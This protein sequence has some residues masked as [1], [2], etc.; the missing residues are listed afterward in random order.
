MPALPARVVPRLTALGALAVVCF[1]SACDD[2]NSPERSPL[3]GLTYVISTD[4][5][6]SFMPAAPL[7]LVPGYFVGTVLG[8]KLP[9]SGNDSL[10]TMPRIAGAVVTAYPVLA[11]AGAFATVGDAEATAVTDA[12]GKFTLPEVPG[13]PYMLAV[14]PPEGSAFVGQYISAH[15]YSESH[16]FA[17]WL[18]LDRK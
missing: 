13:G 16:L 15:A 8:A 11:G 4:S 2:L 18:I 3:E 7:E 1:A 12:N 9:G 6:G 10:A 5:T 17:H 14:E